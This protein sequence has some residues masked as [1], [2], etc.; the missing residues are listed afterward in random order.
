M[1]QVV[2]DPVIKRN[3]I[4]ACKVT[5]NYDAKLIFSED[6][7]HL[8]HLEKGGNNLKTEGSIERGK[9]TCYGSSC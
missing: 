8:E 2:Y 1:F 6:P 4:P 9:M 3:I 7:G 5:L